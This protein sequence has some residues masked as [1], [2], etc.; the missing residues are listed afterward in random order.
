MKT[1]HFFRLGALLAVV[2]VLAGPAAAQ[3]PEA[4]LLDALS[5][6]SGGLLV[7]PD[8]PPQVTHDGDR[9]HVRVPLPVLT[10]PPNAAINVVATP[11]ANGAWDITSLTLPPASSITTQDQDSAPAA[12]TFAIGQQAFHGTI[13]PSL[14]VPSPFKAEMGRITL[15]TEAPGQHMDQTIGHYGMEGTLTGDA[16]KR[17][18]VRALGSLAN[19]L[20]TSAGDDPGTGFRASARAVTIRYE[21]DGLDR[22]RAERL[23]A[24]ARTLS[25]DR[26]DA[27][28]AAPKGTMPDLSPAAV[29]QIAA[30]IDA[31]GGLMTRVNLD[32]TIQDVHFEGK[33]TG[34]VDIGK[35][36]LGVAGDARNGHLTAYLDLG[37][38]NPV[39]SMVPMEYAGYMPHRLVIRPALAGIRTDALLQLL[40]DAAAGTDNLPILQS[41]A[42]A[43]LNEPGARAG[44]ETLLIESGPLRVEGSARIRPQPNGP[45][46]FDVHLAARGLD[47]LISTLQRDP[48]AMQVLPMVFM[49][50]G[51]AK[52]QGD[53][54]VWDIAYNGGAV[55][56]N[57]TPL[58]QDQPPARRS[59]NRR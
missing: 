26:R 13:D 51:M 18:N 10:A 4:S 30:M 50:K 56:V 20:M 22:A 49:A 9:Y 42:E 15:R 24:A 12:M 23:R 43:L 59:P 14:A 39:S 55:M 5:L 57:G 27:M 52:P 11:L 40:R 32:E 45:L 46:A 21:I 44:I 37:V 58:G 35:I 1:S 2:P 47:A 8:N 25:A 36:R 7:Q 34:S 31:L 38:S 53:A 16:E 3:T 54:L 29:E 19:W 41:R 17:L 28:A 33:G 6:I 48:Q